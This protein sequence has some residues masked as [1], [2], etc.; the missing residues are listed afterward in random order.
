M[1][2]R[3]VLDANTL[4]AGLPATSGTLAKLIDHWRRGAFQVVT[5]Q[6]IMEEVR[7]GWAKPYWRRRISSAQ[8]DRGLRLIAHW[9]EVTPITVRADGVAKH[10]EDD[11]VIATALSGRADFLVT[12][13]IPF[14]RVGEY[15]GVTILTP[16]EF[17]DVLDRV[18]HRDE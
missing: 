14:R 15:E 13:D 12:S 5:S 8:V 17:L 2:P 16:R 10:S 4:I 18:G 7:R 6:H 1:K 3:A 11:L 9:A